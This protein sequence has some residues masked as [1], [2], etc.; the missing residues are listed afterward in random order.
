MLTRWI[1]IS[2]AEGLSQTPSYLV[3]DRHGQADLQTGFVDDQT[4]RN[5]IETDLRRMHRSATSYK[6]Y[7]T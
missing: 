6:N 7:G 5:A 2:G 1:K 4:M 3:I